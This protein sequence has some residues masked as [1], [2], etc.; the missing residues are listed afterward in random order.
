MFTWSFPQS[1]HLAWRRG[2]GRIGRSCKDG[3]MQ[4][5]M[6]RWRGIVGERIR[7]CEATIS[8]AQVC[9]S[10]RAAGQ[11]G[12][13]DSN[14]GVAACQNR[15]DRQSWTPRRQCGQC[16]DQVCCVGDGVGSLW[17]REWRRGMLT[18]SRT[19]HHNAFLGD[20]ICHRI[21][22]YLRAAAEVR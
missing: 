15:T 1:K 19:H 10:D 16:S 12:G 4:E 13:E 2:V 7:I 5:R 14:G 22:D 3:R 20:N 21:G 17:V 11:K 6:D 8:N 9:A 18:A